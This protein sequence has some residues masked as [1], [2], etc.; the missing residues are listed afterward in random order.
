MAVVGSEPLSFK[1]SEGMN[2][3]RVVN[4]KALGVPRA[5]LNLK[6]CY[7]LAKII[8]S[9]YRASDSIRAKP[10]IRKS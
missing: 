10:R 9:V 1:N 8:T 4:K 6:L 3:R 5:G 7:V 2:L